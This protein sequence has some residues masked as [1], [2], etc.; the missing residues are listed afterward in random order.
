MTL[1]SEGDRTG[2]REHFGESLDTNIFYYF[3]YSWSHAFLARMDQD[4]TWPPWI[5]LIEEGAAIQPVSDPA[6]DTEDN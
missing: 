2:A 5:P 6:G 1:L 3:D 4:P